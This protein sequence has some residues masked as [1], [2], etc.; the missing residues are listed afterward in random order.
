MTDLKKGLTEL[1]ADIAAG[2][3][4]AVQFTC[5]CMEPW[6]V[7]GHAIDAYRGSLD[8]AKAL[9]EAVLPNIGPVLDLVSGDVA[10]YKQIVN[11]DGKG[12]DEWEWMFTVDPFG[13]GAPMP[14]RAWLIAILRAL[15]AKEDG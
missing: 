7:W 14:A 2:D 6:D 4:A 10:M 8:A 9:H 1:L 12:T 13:P 3:D 11:D 5:V 15:I